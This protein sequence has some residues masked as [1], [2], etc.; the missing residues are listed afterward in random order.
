MAVVIVISN[1]LVDFILGALRSDICI[2]S[3]CA[4]LTGQSQSIVAKQAIVI[5]ST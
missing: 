2:V 5:V 4:K 1:C 3:L